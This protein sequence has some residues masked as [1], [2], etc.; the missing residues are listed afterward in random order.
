MHTAAHLYITS[1]SLSKCSIK[2]A[3]KKCTSCLHT[4][5]AFQELHPP[6]HTKIRC[7]SLDSW[8]ANIVVHHDQ[9]ISLGNTMMHCD[10]TGKMWGE[11]SAALLDTHISHLAKVLSPDNGG[12]LSCSNQSEIS[13]VRQS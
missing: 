8:V 1:I 3:I 10:S 4:S 6:L 7:L 5:L 2:N 13:P 9:T 12:N 11:G